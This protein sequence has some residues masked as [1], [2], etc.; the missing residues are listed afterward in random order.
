[1]GVTNAFLRELIKVRRDGVRIAVAAE[2]GVDVLGG[3]PE[4]VGTGPGIRGK[5][6]SE[7][8]EEQRNAG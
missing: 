1:M 8:G 6:E 5:G 3:D 7:D 4:D 2:V